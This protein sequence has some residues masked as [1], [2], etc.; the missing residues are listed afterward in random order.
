MNCSLHG[1]QFICY[2]TSMSKPAEREVIMRVIVFGAGSVGA[3]FGGRLAQIGEEVTF[4]ARG[5][6]L[7]AMK[8][9]GLRVDSIK[10]DFHLS[11]VRA[12]DDPAQAGEADV[13]LVAVKSWQVPETAQALRPVVGAHTCVVP[14]QNGVEAPDQLAAELGKEHVLGGLCRISAMITAPGYIRHVGIEPFIA[15]GELDNRPSER[16]E[17]LRQ[18]FERAGVT[19]TVPEDIQAAMWEKF[20]FIASVSGVGGVT[21]APIGIFRSIPEGRK[22][23][24]GALSEICE[25]AQSR[26][27]NLPAYSVTKTLGLIDSLPPTTTA[28]MQRDILEGRP[29]E[30]ESQNGAVVRMGREGHVPTPVNE[31]I[32]ASLLPQELRARE[33]ISF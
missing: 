15:F 26:Q 10:G 2:K 30:L 5:A 31:I 7:E 21:R 14:L 33:K 12:T 27:I 17:R 28:S 16:V 32:Y 22:L 9:N 18:A 29:S 19:V 6:H 11:P 1:E 24:E 4:I 23:L 13:V 20:L 3:Y 8:A 25:V